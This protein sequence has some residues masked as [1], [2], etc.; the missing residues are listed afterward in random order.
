[1]GQQK[2]QD[3]SRPAVSGDQPLE[4]G[5]DPLEGLSE[6]PVRHT[7]F[8]WLLM[9]SEPEKV[10]GL[11]AQLGVNID[12][13]GFGRLDGKVAYRIG[14]RSLESP[15]LLI[16]RETFLPLMLSYVEPRNPDKKRVTVRFGNFKEA[17]SGWYPYR[18][19]YAV[20]GEA[21]QRF[22]LLNLRVN[23]PLQASFF[24]TASEKTGLSAEAETPIEQKEEERLKEAIRALEEKYED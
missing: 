7:T 9:G 8:R 17:G 12:E 1:M 21:T 15:K 16:D 10:L 3:V 5:A 4:E 24:E 14:D 13:V 6:K 18:V 22:F 20:E 2:R 19:D 23:P 11:L